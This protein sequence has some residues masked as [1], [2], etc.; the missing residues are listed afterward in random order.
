MDGLGDASVFELWS[1]FRDFIVRVSVITPN[2]LRESSRNPRRNCGLHVGLGGLRVM[3]RSIVM[4][5]RRSHDSGWLGC[6]V[7]PLAGWGPK[8]KEMDHETSFGIRRLC[9]NY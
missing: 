6:F 3:F 8:I 7:L 9:Q 5:K 4:A 1:F 2:A